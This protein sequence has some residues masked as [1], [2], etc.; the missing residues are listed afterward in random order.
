[1]N[2]PGLDPQALEL[3]RGDLGCRRLVLPAVEHGLGQD[4]VLRS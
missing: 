3:L 2:S 1:M 4:A